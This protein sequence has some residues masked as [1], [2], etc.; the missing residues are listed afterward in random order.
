MIFDTEEV[1]D[2]IGFSVV[3]P[4]DINCEHLDV[5]NWNTGTVSVLGVIQHSKY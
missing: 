5:T 1:N 3:T 4:V 2:A